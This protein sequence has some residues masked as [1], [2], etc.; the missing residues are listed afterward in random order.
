MCL[1]C[2]PLGTAHGSCSYQLVVK[3]LNDPISTFLSLELNL[4]DHYWVGFDDPTLA[5]E[6]TD[7]HHRTLK[8]TS[9]CSGGQVLC[10]DHEWPSQPSYGDAGVQ[11]LWR[12][13]GCNLLKSSAPSPASQTRIVVPA[14][15]DQVHLGCKGRVVFR[16]QQGILSSVSAALRPSSCGR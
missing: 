9:R 16:L 6:P 4:S 14:V 1:K 7:G 3:P 13:S 11:G 10:Y 15:V 5:D 12:R 8:V 2:E